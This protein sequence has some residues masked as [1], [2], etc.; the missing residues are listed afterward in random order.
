MVLTITRIVLG[1][2]IAGLILAAM[3]FLYTDR[4]VA[5]LIYAVT[6]VVFLIAAATDWLDGYFARKLNAVT[7]LGAALDHCADKVL[8]ACTLLALACAAL[9]FDVVADLVIEFPFHL[10]AAEQR[11]EPKR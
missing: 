4:A 1:P 10:L 9:P 7:P 8:I 2:V 6:L 5:G 11:P 3:T